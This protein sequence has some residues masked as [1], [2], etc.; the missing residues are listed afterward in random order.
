MEWPPRSL[1]LTQMDFFLWGFVKDNVYVPRFRRYYTCSRYG[2][3]RP[4][5]ILIRKFSTTCGRR[6]D[7]GLMLLEPLVALTLNS[8]NDKLLLIKLFQLV[9]QLVRVL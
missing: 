6:L 7:I 4:V 3:E 2:S 9:S 5:Q 1:D 8:I